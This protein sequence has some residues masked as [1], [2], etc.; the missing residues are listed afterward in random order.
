MKKVS[1]ILTAALMT[2]V[3]LTTVPFSVSAEET[4]ATN[5]AIPET[6]TI[7]GTMQIPY[8]DFYKAEF[9]GATN[10]DVE[11]DAVSSATANKWKGNAVG[12]IDEA[13]GEWKQGG[14]AA[15]TYYEE[16][17]VGGKILG[18][19]Y[20]VAIQAEDYALLSEKYAFTA[21]EDPT[22][23]PIAYKTVTVDGD[24]VTFSKINDTDGEQNVGGAVTLKT[25]TSYGDY[26]IQIENFPKDADTYGAI[27]KTTDGNYYAMRA[28]E[29]IWR[30]G[31]YAWSVGYVTATH[32]NNIDNPDYYATNG[33]T[34][35]EIVMITLDG[36][37]VVSDVDLYL[38]KIFTT[39]VKVENGT[40]G[41]GTVTA[42]VSAFPSDFAPVGTVADGFTV[43]VVDG[44][45]N[46][47]YQGA[48]PANYTLTLTDESGTYADVKG[49]FTLSTDAI[50]VAYDETEGK[51]VTADGYTDDDAANFIK[52]ITSVQV[53]ENTYNTGKRGVTII[54]ADGTIDKEAKSGENAVFG[55]KES[56]DII[57][58]A[59][60]YDNPLT[61]TIGGNS[62]VTPSEPVSTEPVSTSSTASTT[63]TSVT[64]TGTDTGT[65]TGTTSTSASDTT[66]TSTSTT[67]ATTTTTKATTKATTKVNNSN[68]SNN[69]NNNNNATSSTAAPKTGESAGVAPFIA[70]A[71]ILGL[72]GI[73]SKRNDK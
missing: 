5:T 61:F 21:Y 54:K 14:L 63:A 26:Q 2:A 51:L 50:P 43:E 55:E 57:V 18:V 24:T 44:V 64:G 60:G 46:V 8:A 58:K 12:G 42:D 19:V 29:N 73:V 41:E 16:A 69:N 72:A 25:Q 13:T 53:D 65:G 20:P 28:L 22:T 56:Y 71:S 59:T 39:G 70:L 6:G 49:T 15:G 40:A 17:E 48:Q 4:T 33:A 31:Q 45:A 47:N 37:R 27:V 10:S 66:S 9:D 7:Y 68:N 23:A 52:N 11:V 35:D 1:S 67:K 62:A 36:Y 30:N 34:I 3:A 32:G 38:P